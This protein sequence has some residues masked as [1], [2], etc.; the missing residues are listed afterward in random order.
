MKK[1]VNFLCAGVLLSGL[2]VSVTACNNPKDREQKGVDVPF[3]EY[4]FTEGQGE[5]IAARWI[6][7]EY[8][9]INCDG[10][11]LIID[12]DEELKKYVEG[13]Y[14]KVDFLNKSLILAYGI[15]SG[16]GLTR[17]H[18]FR[19]ISD[20]SYVMTAIMRV[21]TVTALFKWHV[22]VVVDKIPSESEI[23]L[24]MLFAN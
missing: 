6:N 10:K 20:R 3:T 15:E 1:L 22:A 4:S 5:D 19:Q 21:S 24:N 23:M 12:S 2:C 17:V 18:E 16:A 13:D 9:E 14:P 8:D 7:L 11:I